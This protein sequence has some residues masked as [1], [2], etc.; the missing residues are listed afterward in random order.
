MFLVC[1]SDQ[2][3]RLGETDRKP[4]RME[5]GDCRPAGSPHGLVAFAFCPGLSWELPRTTP[6]PKLLY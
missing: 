6:F 1:V 5:S 3:R 4:A 2:A